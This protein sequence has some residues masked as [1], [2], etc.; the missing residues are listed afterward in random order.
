MNK[1]PVDILIQFITVV[2]LQVLIF[3]NIQF[4]GF[5]NP[6]VYVLFFLLAPFDFSRSLL[7]IS[8]L[9]MGLIIDLFLG[10]PGIH[11]SA[12]IFIAFIRNEVLKVIAPHGGYELNLLPRISY[13]G[14][15]WFFKYALLM[16]IIHHLVLFYLEALSIA[17]FFHTLLKVILSAAFSLTFIII[18]QY[19]VFRK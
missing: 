19:F 12:T 2:L 11:T 16:V 5:I 4:S 10:T 3:N 1:R 13:M 15:E 17:N 8:G 9:A 7:L 14:F 6:Y 18:S